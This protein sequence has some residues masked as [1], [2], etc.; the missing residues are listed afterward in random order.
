MTAYNEM[1]GWWQRE[2]GVH[3]LHFIDVFGGRRKFE[4][5]QPDKRFALIAG[6]IELFKAFDLHVMIQS[7]EDRDLDAWRGGFNIDADFGPFN[8][9]KSK[10]FALFFL[11]VRIVSRLNAM[12]GPIAP[13]YVFVDEG[14]KQ[15][16]RVMRFGGGLGAA[17]LEAI[18]FGSSREIR[19]IQIADFAA[20][21]LTRSQVLIGKTKFNRW[22]REIATLLG[23][24]VRTFEGV[25]TLERHLL[26]DHATG[27]AVE[28]EG[29]PPE[30]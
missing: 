5:V 2:L 30:S 4:N 3:E 20:F 14:W 17:T 1:L 9:K 21:A 25:K 27:L 10:D 7:M 18:M 24:F 11:L 8:L 15:K 23:P 19:P 12:P 22:D 16:N 28:K 26:I 13:A 29:L 6:M